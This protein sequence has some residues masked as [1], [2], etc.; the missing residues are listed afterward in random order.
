MSTQE[1][2]LHCNR[3]V[4]VSDSVAHADRGDHNPD[5]IHDDKVEP[6]V[7]CLR[8]RVLSKAYKINRC[9]GHGSICKVRGDVLHTIMPAG[10][11]VQSIPIEL[12]QGDHEHSAEP[13]WIAIAQAQDNPEASWA[14]KEGSHCFHGDHKSISRG[15][16]GICLCVFF[17]C[18]VH[19]QQG[20]R[21][22]LK[23]GVML[24]DFCEDVTGCVLI[25]F[26]FQHN[27]TCYWGRIRYWGRIDHNTLIEKH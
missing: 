14:H 10:Q 19:R 6:E 4:E 11:E 15:I 24:T 12:G 1:Q 3:V 2:H 21:G 5:S 23:M 9:H 26:G 7:Q 16:P 17:P 18:G 8:T 20:I 22:T 27:S 25:E 13:G